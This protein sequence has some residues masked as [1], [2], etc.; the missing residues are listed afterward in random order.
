MFIDLVFSGINPVAE[1]VN[2]S[3]E[4]DDLLTT[5]TDDFIV[6]DFTDYAYEGELT[7]DTDTSLGRHTGQLR[8]YVSSSLFKQGGQWW[9]KL[10]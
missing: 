7:F 6:V 5:Q 8:A 4:N 1:F 10:I 2:L 9:S 3:N